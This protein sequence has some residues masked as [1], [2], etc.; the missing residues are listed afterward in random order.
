[1]NKIISNKYFYVGL[2]SALLILSLIVYGILIIIGSD[3]GSDIEGEWT[4]V[5]NIEN[6][7]SYN[8][9]QYSKESLNELKT[10]MSTLLFDKMA[11][12][13]NDKNFYIDDNL[14]AKWSVDN[15][16]IKFNS[17]VDPSVLK[18]D[19]P[20]FT[21]WDFSKKSDWVVSFNNDKTV[22]ELTNIIDST[23][24]LTFKKNK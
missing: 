17:S 7:G 23:E 8:Q 16:V 9:M 10:V 19:A 22:M 15:E 12:K 6:I 14:I 11:F 1:M 24:V 2:I 5:P 4:Y 3:I 21:A 18:E 20:S 13:F